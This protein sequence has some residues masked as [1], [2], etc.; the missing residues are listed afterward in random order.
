[1]GGT[2]E[3]S[4]PGATGVRRLVL[5]DVDDPKKR[6]IEF[7]ELEDHQQPFQVAAVGDDALTHHSAVWDD[8][9]CGSTVFELCPVAC[10]GRS[11]SYDYEQ[12]GSSLTQPTLNGRHSA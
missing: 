4:A 7:S 12:A 2:F 6:A 10:V 5:S 11:P 9:R 3:Q 1:M 8:F